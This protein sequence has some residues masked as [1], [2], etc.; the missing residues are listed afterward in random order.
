ML[1]IWTQLIAA[2]CPTENTIPDFLKMLSQQNI[3]LIVMVTNFVEGNEKCNDYTNDSSLIT[4][5]TN[6]IQNK[7]SYGNITKYRLQES[8]SQNDPLQLNFIKYM[9][10]S[11]IESEEQIN[12]EEL[13]ESNQAYQSARN[14]NNIFDYGAHVKEE[15]V[16]GEEGEEGEDNK[17][18]DE[19]YKKD[20]SYR[21]PHPLKTKYSTKTQTPSYNLEEEDY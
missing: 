6:K 20:R 16:E 19:E 2:Q 13:E 11:E 7:N 3:D 17:D 15:Y 18:E 14:H 12:I 4:L 8:E 5:E 10:S 21:E 9:E 1:V